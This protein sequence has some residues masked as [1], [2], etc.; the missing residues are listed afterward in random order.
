MMEANRIF[1]LCYRA[2]KYTS[3]VITNHKSCCHMNSCHG[4]IVCYDS[5]RQQYNVSIT[6]NN[7]NQSEEYITALPPGV[8]EPTYVLQEETNSSSYHL[9]RQDTQSS[10]TK[11]IQLEL[12]KPSSVQPISILQ[13]N[14][15]K[16]CFLYDVF[17]L[18]LLK[19]LE[20]A[21]NKH[22]AESAKISI[23]RQDFESCYKRM[24][25]SHLDQ[26]KDGCKKQRRVFDT[27]QQEQLQAVYKAQYEHSIA[28]ITP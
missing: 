1:D 13:D 19:E 24:A 6:S 23:D 11:V 16:C 5:L 7:V 18:V 14:E 17:E 3:F 27:H 8:M 12:P 20:K 21:E 9:S 4:N 22:V 2:D 15:V 28:M 26:S 25:S 10:T